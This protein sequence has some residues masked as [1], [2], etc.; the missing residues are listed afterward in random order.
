MEVLLYALPLLAL[1]APLVCGRFVGEERILEARRRRIS[2]PRRRIR[3]HRW[4]RRREVP[5]V[6]VLG[7]APRSLRGPPALLVIA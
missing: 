1:L 3:A 6:S 2:S 7:R 5:I 4:S